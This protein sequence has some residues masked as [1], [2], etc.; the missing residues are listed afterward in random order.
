MSR[1]LSLFLAVCVSISVYVHWEKKN[2]SQI[3]HMPLHTYL[4]NKADSDSDSDSA[5]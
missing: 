2:R 1:L 3:P 5:H 4:A